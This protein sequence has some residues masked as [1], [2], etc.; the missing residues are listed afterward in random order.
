MVFLV[1][2]GN[3]CEGIGDFYSLAASK[4]V[5]SVHQRVALLYT[6]CRTPRSEFLAFAVR[7]MLRH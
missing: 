4:Q 6:D 7:E 2:I 1:F 3:F 5:W